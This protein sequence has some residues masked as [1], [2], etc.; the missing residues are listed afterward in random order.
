MTI[1]GIDEAGRG[2]VCGPMVMAIAGIDEE[3]I[4]IL[5]ELGVKDSK[6]IAKKKRKTIRN[7]L[8]RILEYEIVIIS[9]TE[10]DAALNS[11]SS[12]LNWLEAE[13]SAEIA[14]KLHKRYPFKTLYLDCPSNNV[15]AYTDFFKNSFKIKNVKIIAR[16]KA[17]EIYTIVGAASIL[18]KVLRDEEIEKFKKRTGIECGSGYSSDPKTIE[19]LKKHGDKYPNFIRRTW[20]TYKRIQSTKKQRSLF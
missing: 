9:P 17:D 7:Q 20:S 4:D 19:F 5:V 3:K 6:Q 16:H 10:I 1:A 15:T 11:S 13:K 8:T 14:R 18:A 2:P 12:N